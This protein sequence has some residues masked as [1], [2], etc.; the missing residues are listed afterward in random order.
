MGQLLNLVKKDLA[1]Q[2][3][4]KKILIIAVVLMFSAIASPILA[5]IMP[6]ILKSV[7]TQ[8][9]TITLPDPSY[10]DAIDQFIKNVSQIGLLV[11]VFV[12]ASA[13]TDEKNKR[14]LEIVMTKPISRQIFVLSKYVAYFISLA[15]IFTISSLIFYQYSVDIFSEYSWNNFIIMSK[16]IF[17][18]II[19]VVSFT[20]M[21]STLVKNSI[22]AGGIGFVFYLLFG[23]ILS[24][25]QVVK[26]YSPNI[27][28]SNYQEILKSGY[29]DDLAKPLLVI[30]LVVIFSI[31]I[32]MLV[33]RHQE[34]EK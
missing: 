7:S 22:V 2:W 4:T 27:I 31:S 24:M 33:F 32:S 34:I 10:K 16:C 8:V 29:N 14:T 6:E 23:T 1:E 11:L 3:R 25:I 20:I 12:V 28:L 19:M 26:D 9:I 17:A 21:A 15:I 13:M 5:K 30:V 18:F